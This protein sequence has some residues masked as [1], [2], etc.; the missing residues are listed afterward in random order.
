MRSRPSA[1]LRERHRSRST[2]QTSRPH[3]RGTPSSR[4]MGGGLSSNYDSRGRRGHGTCDVPPRRWSENRAWMRSSTKSRRRQL[5]VDVARSR[6]GRRR[7]ARLETST[8]FGSA[9]AGR[10]RVSNERL[11][12]KRGLVRQP[13]AGGR[14]PRARSASCLQRALKTGLL[15]RRP[16]RPPA[17]V[18]V[19]PRRRSIRLYARREA[20]PSRRQARAKYARAVGR[21]VRATLGTKSGR[22]ARFTR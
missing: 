20:P 15:R 17:R 13:R 8:V 12:R 1:G 2:W 21:D 9:A 4:S 14:V 22:A 10:R 7:C 5:R 3:D 11:T 18:V 16:S 19:D 6:R